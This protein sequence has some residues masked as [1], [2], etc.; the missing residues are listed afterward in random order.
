[1]TA[2]F[3]PESREE[4][5]TPSAS[6][7]GVFGGTFDPPHFGHLRTVVAVQATL[8]L[9]KILVVPVGK[10]PHRQEPRASPEHRLAMVQRAFQD[11]P[12]F[13]CDDRE[14]RRGGISYTVL[15]IEELRQEL[16]EGPLCLILGLD[17]FLDL[18]SWN[19]WTEILGNAH[20]VVM[21]R[22]G[23]EPP[24]LL[25][26]WWLDAVQENPDS[27]YQRS[28]G[29]VYC[30][31]VPAIDHAS[32]AIRERL[33]SSADVSDAVPHSVLDYIKTHQI[34]D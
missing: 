19:R 22:L 34:Y 9:G 30:V 20:I 14:I 4:T 7:V 27:L 15:T 16:G 32:T 23:W 12:G 21:H 1:M 29:F 33:S 28:G 25:P 5:S 2:A 3:D 31:P 26:D 8:D 10:P 6:A 18:P 11:M 24:S 17:S 13:E